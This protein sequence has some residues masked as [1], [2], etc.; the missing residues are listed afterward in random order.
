M[1]MLSSTTHQASLFYVAFAREAA[2]IKDDLLEP[3]DTLL[4]DSTLVDLIRDAQASRCPRSRT[5]GRRTVAP[6]RLL[7]CCALKHVKNWSFRQLERE[8]RGSLVYRRFTHFDQDPI[9]DYSTLSRNFAMLGP[10]TTQQIHARVVKRALEERVA[11]GLKLR[12]DT[13][14]VESNV[15]YPTDSTLLQDGIRVLTRAVKRIAQECPTGAVKIID[16]A[17]SAQRRVLEIHRAAKSFTESARDRMKESY[18]GLMA[19]ARRVVRTAEKVTEELKSGKL[20]VPGNFVRVLLNEAHLRHFTPL[21]KKVLAQTK[22]RVF[23]GD[24]HVEGKILSLFEE[25]T[26][27]ICKGKAHKPTEFGRL[28][29]ID[30]VENG[31]VSAY[32]VQ[33]GNPA[34]VKAWVPALEQHER[35]FGRAPKRA[36]ADRGFFSAENEREAKTRGVKQVALPAR[37]RLSKARAALQKQG[38]FRR[39]LRWRGG[40]EPRIANLKHRFGMER[41]F[42]KGDSGFKRFVGWSVISQNLV[43]IARVLSR[44]KARQEHDTESRRAA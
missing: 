2:L 38:W 21:V 44:R 11:A 31:V 43:S 37:G 40:I 10:A 5:M 33:D 41:A 28:V 9:P 39:M 29:R 27:V 20:P 8:L 17:R 12:T 24:R 26:Q 35:L 19:L 6:D 14:V 30:E 22:A 32:E 18:G 1:P 15:H 42:Y 25:H 36:T 16:H 13:T 7:R 4:D 34:D 23:G 3:I